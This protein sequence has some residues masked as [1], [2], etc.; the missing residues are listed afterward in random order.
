MALACPAIPTPM[1]TSMSCSMP[2]SMP[3]S[4]SPSKSPFNPPC[5]RL[6]RP[7]AQAT[8][9]PPPPG[10]PLACQIGPSQCRLFLPTTKSEVSDAEEA[11]WQVGEKMDALGLP[12]HYDMLRNIGIQ[13]WSHVSTR[14]PP[15]RRLEK[16]GTYAS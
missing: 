10:H 14:P 8:P 12:I 3:S 11:N 9:R 7:Q 6:G 2:R 16:T 15:T 4:M 13:H 1:P 5:G